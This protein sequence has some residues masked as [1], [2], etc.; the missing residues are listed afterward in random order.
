MSH[1]MYP[2]PRRGESRLSYDDGQ[3]ASFRGYF[4]KEVKNERKSFLFCR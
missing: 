4:E 3:L 2:F 1:E